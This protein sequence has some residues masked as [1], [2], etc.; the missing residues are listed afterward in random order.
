MPREI[1]R[2]FL[3]ADA[4]WRQAVSTSLRLRDGL[5][6]SVDGRKVRVR[7]LEDRAFLTVKGPRE[8][9]SRDE[10]EYE[11]PLA[12]GL[13]ML[14]HCQGAT[15]EKTRHLVPF[16]GFEWSVDEYAPPLDGVILAEIELPAEDAV[17]ARPPWLGREVTGRD[18][19]RKITMLRA[20]LARA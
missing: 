2:K 14:D 5:L 20:R 13:A 10:F 16:A 8:G 4:G 15:L 7:C 1:E 18:E 11:I 9:I 19:Y 12:D 6:A 17:F 3:V